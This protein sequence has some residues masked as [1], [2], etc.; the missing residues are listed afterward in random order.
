MK[1][2]SHW[3]DGR[4]VEGTS[5][6]SAPVYDPATGEQSAAV[7]LASLDEVDR[8]IAV[9]EAA[10]PEWRATSLSRRAEILFRMRELVDANRKE[11]AAFLTAEHGK[12]PSVR[13]VVPGAFAAALSAGALLWPLTPLGPWPLLAVA[14]PYAAVNLGASLYLAYR[15]GWRHLPLLPPTFA[16]LHLAY[17]FGFLAGLLLIRLFERPRLV[18]AKLEG[19]VLR[20]DELGPWDRW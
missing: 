8:A 18:R 14:A 5:G 7:D 19:H 11:I 13:H 15:D 17:G 2:I 1:R 4:I 3:I 10:A 12:V 16:T 20:R 9:A 6:N